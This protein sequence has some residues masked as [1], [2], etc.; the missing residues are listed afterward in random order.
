[1]PSLGDDLDLSSLKT[2][3]TNSRELVRDESEHSEEAENERDHSHTE[4]VGRTCLSFHVCQE[5][6][7]LASSKQ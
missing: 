5:S 1:M 7:C 3:Q 6:K 2:E 4:T